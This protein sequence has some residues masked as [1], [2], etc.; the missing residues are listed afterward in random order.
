MHRSPLADAADR[1]PNLGLAIAHT[2]RS[3]ALAY[4]PRC[5]GRAYTRLE[6]SASTLR[7]EQLYGDAAPSADADVGAEAPRTTRHRTTATAIAMPASKGAFWRALRKRRTGDRSG[8]S[9]AV[10]P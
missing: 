5:L 9:G 7:A 3:R 4:C 8:V 6:M 2:E 1:S 10:T